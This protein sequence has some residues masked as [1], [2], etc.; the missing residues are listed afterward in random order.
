MK[1][2][3]RCQGCER[4]ARACGRVPPG[5]AGQSPRRRVPGPTAPIDAASVTKG[6][7]SRVARPPQCAQGL[8][9]SVRCI[10]RYRSALVL[11]RP[12][13][14]GSAVGVVS[15]SG[16]LS[17]KLAPNESPRRDY[18]VVFIPDYGPERQYDRRRS[19]TP[20]S[21]TAVGQGTVRRMTQFPVPLLRT[22]V[23]PARSKRVRVPL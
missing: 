23:K 10:R 1:S 18:R 16:D 15:S 2:A 20:P 3:R 8:P 12:P 5:G 11:G 14:G 4:I 22:N 13:R 21:M 7:L 19:H 9:S 17:R 6:S